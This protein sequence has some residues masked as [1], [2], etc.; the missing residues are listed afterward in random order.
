[1]PDI[2]KREF[3]AQCERQSAKSSDKERIRMKRV[4]KTPKAVLVDFCYDEQ[5]VATSGGGNTA[6]YGDPNHIGRCQQSSETTCMYFWLDFSSG[7][8]Q[9]KPFSLRGFPVA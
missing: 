6:Q 7:I 9:S 8:C 3:S 1:M 4:Y 5:V 2:L